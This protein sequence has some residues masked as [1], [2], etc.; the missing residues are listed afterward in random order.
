LTSIFEGFNSKPALLMSNKQTANMFD[1]LPLIRKKTDLIDL[2]PM[3]FPKSCA[4]IKA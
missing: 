2:K 3:V 1:F 4:T